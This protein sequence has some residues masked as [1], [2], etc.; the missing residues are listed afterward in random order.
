M[1]VTRA[2]ISGIGQVASSPLLVVL[3]IVLTMAA[4]VP[5]GVVLR[6][7]LEIALATQPPVDLGSSEVDADW[8][9]EFRAHAD[10]LAATFTP[11][12]IGFAAPLDNLSALLD[13][14]QRPMVLA[15][16]IAIS[17]VMWAWLW[18]VALR[19]FDLGRGLTIGEAIQSGFSTLPRFVAISVVAA[20]IQI[21][22][23]LTIHPLMFQAAYPAVIGSSMSEPAAFAV[24]IVFYLLF[25]L[26]VVVVSLL[27]DY[28]RVAQV[29][30]RPLALGQA[31]SAANQFI[32]SRFSAVIALYLMTGLLFAVMM[33]AY[34]VIDSYG[35]TRV[36]GWRG[37][38]IG[39]AFICGRLVIRLIFGA[40]ELQFFKA[41]HSQPS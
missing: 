17:L 29:V 21:A 27:A 19:R 6:S 41:E 36:G 1:T 12:V 34:G 14:S 40:S 3:T 23:Y 25:G 28:A 30:L 13:G 38:A 8:W 22:L 10:G 16:P 26:L 37:I 35:G 24:R 11:T 4:A 2:W 5:F 7:E 31:L 33:T 18:G 39:Q 32:R 9:S 15:L 20:V